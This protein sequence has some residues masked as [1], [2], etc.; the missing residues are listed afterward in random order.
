MNSEKLEDISLTIAQIGLLQH[1]LGLDKERKKKMEAYR[2]Y[3]SGY[4]E[5]FE[6]LVKK[7]LAY[8]RPDPF[9]PENERRV[10]YHVNERGKQALKL[11]IGDFI[12]RD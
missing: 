1:T 5:G 3:Y 7:D 9:E 6:D 4:S 8:K 12:E 2:N 10:V 11:I